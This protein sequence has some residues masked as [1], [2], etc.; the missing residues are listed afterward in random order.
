MRFS[1][2]DIKNYVR[3]LP[4]GEQVGFGSYSVLESLA[5]WNLFYL[6]EPLADIAITCSDNATYPKFSDMIYPCH[7]ETSVN[8]ELAKA[9]ETLSPTECVEAIKS[10]NYR[11]MEPY[12]LLGELW[13][14]IMEL[15]A[16]GPRG[17]I[18]SSGNVV[19]VNFGGSVFNLP[20]GISSCNVMTMSF[21]KH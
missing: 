19:S 4:S 9:L 8:K 10:M 16:A 13:I 5:A 7:L 15:K 18:E 11:A 6:S 14:N 2:H 20:N 21:T 1:P 17:V 12:K 3:T